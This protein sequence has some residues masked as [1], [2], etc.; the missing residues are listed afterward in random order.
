MIITNVEGCQIS[1][2]IILTEIG[3]ASF[4]Y[5]SPSLQ[6]EG[7]VKAREELTFTNTSASP[8][9]YS[10]WIF[11]D[12]KREIVNRITGTVS[13]VQHTY[14]TSGSYL[15]TLRNYNRLGCFKEITQLIVVGKGYNVM[16]PN[17]F[18]PNGD[19]INDTFR[20][21]FSGFVRVKFTVYDNFGNI[22]YTE[23]IEEPN[24]DFPQGI[25]LNGWDGYNATSSTSYIYRFEGFTFNEEDPI[26]R[27]GTFILLR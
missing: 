3:T 12:G 4:E 16:V 21:L 14:G 7:Q 2:K 1:E 5:S 15:V 8:Y 13:P 19:L 9:H 26:I 23:S 20:A 6:I 27:S 25:K 11:G 17:A 10:E 22:L 18:S 24:P